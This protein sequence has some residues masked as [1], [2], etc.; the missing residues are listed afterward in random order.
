MIETLMSTL[1]MVRKKNPSRTAI[2]DMTK[3]LSYREVDIVTNRM[4]NQI[5]QKIGVNRRVVVIL[6]HGINQILAL[7]A[8]LKS[9]NCYVPKGGISRF[10]F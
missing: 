6:P 9:N 5:M 2:E 4:A 1:E 8:I 3:G 10:F 7:I